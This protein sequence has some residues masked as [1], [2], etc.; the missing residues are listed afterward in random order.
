[1]PELAYSVILPLGEGTLG[2][3]WSQE[4]Q[5][6]GDRASDSHSGSAAAAQLHDVRAGS[7]PLQT[8][9]FPS[10]QGQMGLGDPHSPR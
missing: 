6:P 10:V 3:L 1:M 9:F 7:S 5:E 4:K 2:K 8:S